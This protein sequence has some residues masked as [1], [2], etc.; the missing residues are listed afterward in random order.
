VGRDYEM[1]SEDNNL[2][3]SSRQ[4][5]SRQH[6]GAGNMTQEEPEGGGGAVV[7]IACLLEASDSRSDRH[8]DHGMRRLQKRFRCVG[9]D[10]E[11]VA[12]A[13]TASIR[14]PSAILPV[15]D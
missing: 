12:G 2:D 6:S 5:R 15:M 3:S 8:H 11:E 13:G 9:S 7:A 14:G 1:K 4:D 10:V